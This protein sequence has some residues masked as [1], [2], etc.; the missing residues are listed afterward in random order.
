M[1]YWQAILPAVAAAALSPATGVEPDI[2]VPVAYTDNV[3]V[4]IQMNGDLPTTRPRTMARAW[5]VAYYATPSFDLEGVP[6][7]FT[8]TEFEID[9]KNRMSRRLSATAFRDNGDRLGRENYS[10]SWTPITAANYMGDMRRLA[11]EGVGPVDHIY[12]NLH[13]AVGAH[14]R[15]VENTLGS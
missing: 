8:Q 13:A 2:Y 15:L 5:Q 3:V 1:R 11:C 6:V 14:Q 10:D 4:V 7:Q 9:C 12:T